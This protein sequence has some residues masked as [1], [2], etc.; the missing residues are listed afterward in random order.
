MLADPF[1]AL[2]FTALTVEEALRRASAGGCARAQPFRR[3]ADVRRVVR[4]GHVVGYDSLCVC[5]RRTAGT[6]PTAEEAALHA[7][8]SA[9]AGRATACA[10]KRAA[11][12]AMSAAANEGLTPALRAATSGFAFV[13]RRASKVRFRFRLA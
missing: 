10:A 11:A 6:Y 5:A 2:G 12:A 13:E 3:A 7:A 9:A 1:E 8:R 4:Q